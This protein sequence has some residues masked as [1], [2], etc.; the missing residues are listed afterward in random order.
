M[1]HWT[2]L[3]HDLRQ[4]LLSI[5]L[6]DDVFVLAVF[7]DFLEEHG[8][9]HHELVRAFWQELQPEPPAA[10]VNAF[11][12]EHLSAGP[13]DRPAVG[14]LYAIRR[15]ARL[16]HEVDLYPA[17]ARAYRRHLLYVARDYILKLYAE[18]VDRRQ[19]PLYD[20]LRQQGYWVCRDGA[21]VLLQEMDDRH[22]RSIVQGGWG[23]PQRT[24]VLMEAFARGLI[25][26]NEPRLQAV[27]PKPN[28]DRL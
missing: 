21:A 2:Q 1:T 3:P 8:D 14:R 19:G 15:D 17:A 26:K 11:L 10:E 4:F 24:A 6:I 28:P 12:R 20:E 25:D 13:A 5:A 23:G 18:G 22:L 9:P 7:G 27:V 16:N